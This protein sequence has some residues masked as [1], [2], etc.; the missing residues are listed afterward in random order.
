MMLMDFNPNAV[1]RK[2]PPDA[3]VV[4]EPTIILRNHFFTSDVESKLP[5]P[6]TLLVEDAGDTTPEVADDQIIVIR[7]VGA[8]IF[9]EHAVAKTLI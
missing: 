8:H 9:Q 4:T 2:H 7:N 6:W 5:Y 1:R 3:T